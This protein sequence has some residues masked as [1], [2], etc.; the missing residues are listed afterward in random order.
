MRHSRVMREIPVQ[1]GDFPGKISRLNACFGK[2]IIRT[3]ASPSLRRKTPMEAWAE[4]TS[5]KGTH[6][7]KQAKKRVRL[8]G[9][10]VEWKGEGTLASPWGCCKVER[11]S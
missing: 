4:R 6:V 3:R 9:A 11:A 1:S 7:V 8:V 10:G 2:E 5:L